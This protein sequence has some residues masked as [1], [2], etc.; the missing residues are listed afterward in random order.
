MTKVM[1]SSGIKNVGDYLT[2][3]DQVQGKQP[4]PEQILNLEQIKKSIE[5]Q[6]RQTALGERKQASDAQLAQMRLELDTLK[7]QNSHAVQSDGVDLKEA[8]LLHKKVID[9]AELILAQQADQVT[10]IASPNG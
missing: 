3:P 7:A 2:P 6:E 9:A 4:D 5:V 10:A 8:Q 1:E